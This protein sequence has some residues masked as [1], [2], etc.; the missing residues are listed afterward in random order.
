[1]RALQN[2]PTRA[3]RREQNALTMSNAR[4]RESSLE[5]AAR[6]ATEASRQARRRQNQVA[7]NEGAA[8]RGDPVEYFDIGRMDRRCNHCHA[9]LWFLENKKGSK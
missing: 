5:R 3:A 4:T 2:T 6:R 8:L 9:K 1:M 7:Q